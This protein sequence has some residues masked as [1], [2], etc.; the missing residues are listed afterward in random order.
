MRILVELIQ[1]ACGLDIVNFSWYVDAFYIT[2]ENVESI[3][4]CKINYI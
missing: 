4:D 2:F 1:I 3:Y